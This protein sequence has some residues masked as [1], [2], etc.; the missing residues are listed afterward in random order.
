VVVNLASLLVEVEVSDAPAKQAAGQE[1]EPEKG[2]SSWS[3]RNTIKD[4]LIPTPG[5]ISSTPTLKQCGWQIFISCRTYNLAVPDENAVYQAMILENITSNNII[6][7]QGPFPKLR[8]FSYQTYQPADGRPLG[9]IPDFK[10]KPDGDGINPFATPAKAQD[11]MASP[12]TYSLYI[13]PTGKMG[14]P[15]E[16]PVLNITSPADQCDTSPTGCQVVVFFR[17]YVGE[18]NFDPYSKF[19]EAQAQWG[20]VDPPTILRRS[21]LNFAAFD[22]GEKGITPYPV[23]STPTRLAITSRLFDMHKSKMQRENQYKGSPHLDNKD[24]NFILYT[25]RKHYTPFPNM[26]SNY[27]FS[28][29]NP[30]L[31]E[32]Y[33]LMATIEGRLP[34]TPAGLTTD[35]R[36]GDPNSYEVRYV[37]LSTIQPGSFQ[38]TYSALMDKDFETFYKKKWDETNERMYKVVAA[39]DAKSAERCG[40]YNAKENMFLSTVAVDSS[41]QKSMTGAPNLVAFVYRQL[42]SREQLTGKSDHS[43]SYAKKVCQNLAPGSCFSPDMYNIVMRK[44]YPNITFYACDIKTRTLVDIRTLRAKARERLSQSQPEEE[45]EETDTPPAIADPEDPEL[46]KSI[47]ASIVQARDFDAPFPNMPEM[48][49]VLPDLPDLP[50][51]PGLRRLQGSQDARAGEVEE[52]VYSHPHYHHH[53]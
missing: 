43:V 21:A 18:K 46:L 34:I 28:A 11:W 38:P 35:P 47:M 48:P 53:P 4:Y 6:R 10:M 1:P 30:G 2:S 36:I 23:C 41:T 24:T 45:E 20:Y 3:V 29:A 14:Y 40:L 42:L 15:N 19:D 33:V 13:T 9:T 52:E 8:Y 22:K 7:I 5:N 12:D 26:D 32:P 51:L 44:D 49:D 27:L 37:S 39:P 31:M 16:L 25:G 50:D 17:L